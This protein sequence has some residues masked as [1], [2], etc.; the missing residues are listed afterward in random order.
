MSNVA[1]EELEGCMCEYIPEHLRSQIETVAEK[2]NASTSQVVTFALQIGLGVLIG[3][4]PEF[5]SSTSRAK[6]GKIKQTRNST[7]SG[8][9]V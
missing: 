8:K 6:H 5:L 7:L 3:K 1:A 4:T 2:T 9:G